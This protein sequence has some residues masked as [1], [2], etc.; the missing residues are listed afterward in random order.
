M[1]KGLLITFEGMDGSGK[2]TQIKMIEEYLNSKGFKTVITREPGGTIISESIRN[3]VLNNEFK[4]MDSTTELLLYCASRAQLVKE[5]ILPAIENSKI[6]LCDRFIDSTIVYQG[7]ARGIDI[8]FLN[9]LNE[10]VSMGIEPDITFLL[11]ISSQESKNRLNLCEEMDRIENED[12][13]FYNKVCK[14]YNE[15]TKI[16]KKRIKSIDGTK[17]KDKISLIIKNDIENILRRCS[18]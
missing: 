15:I 2:T 7:Y 10:F 16:Y 9:K 5:I 13:N 6:V 3:I 12:S 8:D 1:K 18:L 4:E 11:N 14:G 17:D